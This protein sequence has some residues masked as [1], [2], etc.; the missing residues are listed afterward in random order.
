MKAAATKRLVLDASV[1]LAWCFA[2]ESTAYA[3]A[4]LDLLAS[5][6]AEARAVRYGLQ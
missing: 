1:T 4:M 3:E 2:D 6:D 5:G